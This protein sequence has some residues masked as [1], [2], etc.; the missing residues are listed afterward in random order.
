[1]H[2]NTCVVLFSQF[3]IDGRYV[4]RGRTPVDTPTQ[5]H[6]NKIENRSNDG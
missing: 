4:L 1:M 6:K 2:A 3:V 5:T